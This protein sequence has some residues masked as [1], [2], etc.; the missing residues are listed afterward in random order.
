MKNQPVKL[1]D[2]VRQKIR[3]KHYS[4]RTEEEY[5]G[6]IRRFIL[7]HNKKHPKDMGQKEVEAFLTHLA[8]D[9]KVAAST[10]NQA[11]NA[12]LFLYE[13][14]LELDVIKNIDA[15]R[16][17]RPQRVPTVLTF[18]EVTEVIDAMSGISQLIAKVLYGCGLRGIES[19]RLRVQDVD[20][21]M[22]QIIVRDGK[23]RK[24]RI[25]M[26][27][28]VVKA[29][30]PEHLSYVKKLH[31]KD[32]RDGYGRVYMPDALERKYPNA[33]LTWGWQ[34]VFPSRSLSED[35]RSGNK[36]RHHIH[37]ATLPLG[38]LMFGELKQ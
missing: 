37:L 13:K 36:R 17:K 33:N 10:Q 5:V 14:V 6:W 25:T 35:P 7:Y 27:P 4:I 1:L 2:R 3:L 16:A 28:E 19:V 31:E 11:F 23:G 24:D 8:L 12:L 34:Y 22:D 32:L 18:E 26:L 9:G 30:L 20:F 29:A 21:N 38:G 15:Y